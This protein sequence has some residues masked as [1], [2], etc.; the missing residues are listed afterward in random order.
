MNANTDPDYAE[1]N[2][3]NFIAQQFDCESDE[4]VEAILEHWTDSD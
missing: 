3:E 4:E 2:I 1:D